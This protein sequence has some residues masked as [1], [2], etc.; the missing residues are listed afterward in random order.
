MLV[1][2]PSCLLVS[3]AISVWSP[4]IILTSTPYAMALWIVSLVSGRGGSKKVSRPTISHL[5]AKVEQHTQ[6]GHYDKAMIAKEMEGVVETCLFLK[7]GDKHHSQKNI[8]T[9]I[10]QSGNH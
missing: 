7:D 2:M 6:Q 1:P 10:P 4:V 8:K 9:C 3:L 5:S